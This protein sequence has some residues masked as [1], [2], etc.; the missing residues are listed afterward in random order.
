MA[1]LEN[2]FAVVDVVSVDVVSV[3]VA[4]VDRNVVSGLKSSQSSR[5]LLQ[6]LA[7]LSKLISGMR[8]FLW[9]KIK[10]VHGGFFTLR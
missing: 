2:P 3:D 6:Y 7:L 10:K 8:K 9:E 1:I 4:S 5:I